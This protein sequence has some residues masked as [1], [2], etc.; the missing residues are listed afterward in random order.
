VTA[1][2]GAAP[3]SAVTEIEGRKIVG[4]GECDGASSKSK[5]K[6]TQVS[7]RDVLPVHPAADLFPHDV[8]RRIAERESKGAA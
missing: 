4:T 6:H 8:A 2:N 5:A 1:T 3:D 7:W